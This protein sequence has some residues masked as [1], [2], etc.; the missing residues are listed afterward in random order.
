MCW[1]NLQYAEAAASL[2]DL[3]VTRE[4]MSRWINLV[5]VAG[6]RGGGHGKRA[7]RAGDEGE[8]PTVKSSGLGVERVPASD[9]N[10]VQVLPLRHGLRVWV[11]RAH[12]LSDHLWF[13]AGGRH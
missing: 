2:A 9:E 6:M 8:T 11:P 7:L 10:L 12:D 3:D 4:L 1:L 13:Q 5:A